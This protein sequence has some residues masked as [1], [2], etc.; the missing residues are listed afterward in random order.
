MT[1]LSIASMNRIAQA[2][3]TY[4]ETVDAVYE[5]FRD[6][7]IQGS[8]V[9]SLSNIIDNLEET[10]YQSLGSIS[11]E[12]NTP[13]FNS[14]AN[15]LDELDREGFDTSRIDVDDLAKRVKDSYVR[16]LEESLKEFFSEWRYNEVESDFADDVLT[17]VTSYFTEG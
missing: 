8:M 3:G 9:G 11:S 5:V 6:S 2:M 7:Y 17:E 16:K 4:D 10:L 15:F 13:W 1:D 14:I 12:A